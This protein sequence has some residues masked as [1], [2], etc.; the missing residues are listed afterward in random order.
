VIDPAG[1]TQ[2]IAN[3]DGTIEVVFNGEIYNFAELRGELESNGHSF[4]T[5]TDTE[6][7]VHLWEDHGPEMLQRLNG[8]FAIC[9]HDRKQRRTLIARD[10]LGIKP[11]FYHRDG[12]RI[13]FA[14]EI[15]VLLEHPGVRDD[16][17]A[18][19][20]IELFALQYV[21]GDRTLYQGIRKLPPGCY[22][23]IVDGTVEQK[24]WWTIPRIEPAPVAE[25]EIADR[26]EQLRSLLESSVRY[27]TVA[28]VPLGLFLSGG[29]DSGILCALLSRQSDRPVQSFSVG[30]DD[31]AAFDEREHA[32]TVA[33]AFGTE[34]RELVVS[35]VNIAE[36]LPELIRHLRQ[37]VTDPAILPTWLLSKFAREKVTVVLSGEGADE[38]FGGYRRYLYQDRLGWLG[39]VPGSQ[40]LKSLMPRR[41][42]QALEAVGEDRPAHNHL[43]WSATVGLALATRLFDTEVTRSFVERVASR[44]EPYFESDRVRLGDQLRTDQSE[45]LPHNLLAKVDRASMAHSLEARVPFLDHR[46][47]EW[48]ASQ[49]DDL[50][51]R[52]KLTKF[53]LREAFRETLPQSTARRAKQGFDLPLAAW[54]RGPLRSAAE[55]AIDAA[56]TGLWPELKHHAAREMLDEHL[57]GKQDHGLPLFLLVSVLSFLEARR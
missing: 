57:A 28:D 16:I 15:A 30:F 31:H 54:I 35:P 18:E 3:E 36:H 45:W 44:F 48:A 24:R 25:N 12:E 33:R 34:H 19:A 21:A 1:G 39:K 43:L 4:R 46:I 27:R 49:P 55:Q 37:P 14:S 29:L 56:E 8:M 2:P 40:A 32:R 10:R 11:L 51:I 13:A 6:V 7:L 41:I 22:L 17:D 26:L 52:G 20:L 38:L 9:L 5:R 53:A 47:V 23:D 42:E 50:K